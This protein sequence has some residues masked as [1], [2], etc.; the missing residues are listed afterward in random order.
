VAVPAWLVLTDVDAKQATA[1]AWRLVWGWIGLLPRMRP[2]FVCLACKTMRR[3]WHR[4]C[5]NAL[6]R[7]PVC[8]RRTR[9]RVVATGR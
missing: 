2:A 1:A 6:C 3:A 8:L 5:C 9:W 4:T 7:A